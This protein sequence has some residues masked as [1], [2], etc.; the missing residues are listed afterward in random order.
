MDETFDEKNIKKYISSSI[1]YNCNKKMNS[2]NEKLDNIL[3]LI[4]N[5]TIKIDNIENKININMLNIDKRNENNINIKNENNIDIKNEIKT[6]IKT[7]TENN[8]I[9]KEIKK[10][11]FNIND[12]FI[13]ECLCMSNI[14]GDIKMFKKMYIDNIPKEFYPIRHIKKKLQYWKDGHMIDD[15]QNYVINTIIKNIEE[16]YL[17]INSYD[18]YTNDIDQFMKNQEHI[19]KL[20]EV[21]YKEKIL[22]KIIQIISI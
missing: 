11:C 16:C 19:S 15:E 1:T 10:E 13:K 17:K 4:E 12:N 5:L 3:K 2:Y 14:Q 22:L 7:D 8:F 6:E 20:S 18:S 9:Y 21:K